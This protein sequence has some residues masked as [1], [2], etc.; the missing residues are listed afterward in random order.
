V[1]AGDPDVV[2]NTAKPVTLK[3]KNGSKKGATK[4]KLKKKKPYKRPTL[5]RTSLAGFDRY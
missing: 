5:S 3:S 4:G 2:F 1:I